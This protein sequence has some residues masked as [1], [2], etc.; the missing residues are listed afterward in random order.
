M[1]N[2]WQP[3]HG[4]QTMDHQS[5]PHP[6]YILRRHLFDDAKIH[7]TIWV[8]EIGSEFEEIKGLRDS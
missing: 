3:G 1:S 6:R 4:V 5:G 7:E 2:T 8:P